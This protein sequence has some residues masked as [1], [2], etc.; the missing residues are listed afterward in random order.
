[1]NVSITS[2]G[3]EYEAYTS[4]FATVLNTYL[5]DYQQKYDEFEGLYNDRLTEIINMQHELMKY[6]QCGYCG[7]KQ[8]RLLRGLLFYF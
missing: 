4:L 3:D 6:Y 7:H 2:S 5:V 8:R 1:M